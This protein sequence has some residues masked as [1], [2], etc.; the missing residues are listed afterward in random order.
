MYSL[1]F[2]SMTSGTHSYSLALNITKKGIVRC[3]WWSQIYDWTIIYD[4]K[5]MLQNPCVR[6]RLVG[7]SGKYLWFYQDFA[8]IGKPLLRPPDGAGGSG[9]GCCTGTGTGWD[10]PGGTSP[11]DGA[12]SSLPTLFRI[13]QKILV[14]H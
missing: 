4:I 12:M 3:H 5:E 6:F 11:G 7:S 2:I 10:G 8:H 14:V 9:S 1:L 13:K